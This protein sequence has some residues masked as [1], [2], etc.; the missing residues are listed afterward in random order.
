MSKFNY[1]DAFDLE[2]QLSS[3]ERDVMHQAR[4]FSEKELQPIV[5]QAFRDEQFDLSL[6]KKMG[7]ANLLGLNH[8]YT[9][10]GLIARELERVDSGF[11]TLQSVIGGL[12]SHAIDYFGSDEQKQKYLP[13]IA[14]GECI[15]SFGLT[16]PGHGSDPHNMQT[17][18]KKVAGGYELTGEKR[19]IG[20]A[21]V[22]DIIIVWAKD[23]DDVIR[24]FLV[25]KG[26]K[27]LRV[28]KI[29]GKYSLRVVSSGHIFLDG[30]II[31]EENILPL[32]KG[33]KSPL[34][35]LNHARYGIG[36]GALGAAESC[37]HIAADYIKQRNDFA[38]KQLV[39]AKL[40]DMC[41]EISFALQG[42]LRV[43]HLYDEGKGTP[44]Q[45]S[46]IKRNSTIKALSIARQARD[47]LG[48]NGIVDEYGVIRHMLNLE[49]VCTYEGTADIHSLILG[50]AIAGSNAF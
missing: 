1:M 18:A 21:S 49:S 25:E 44:E 9:E 47:I 36:W 6:I 20:L 24:G 41:S 16:E 12:V 29:A 3:A 40:A 31:P 48:G 45:I 43:A 42:C 34:R 38:T 8:S 27:N 13:K 14:A 33:L 46:L 2:S 26:T 32:S 15:G 30:V 28:E 39:Q 50:R 10:Y 7:D 4:Q 22:A 17:R 5:T 35:C 19:W 11:R 37:L 23:D